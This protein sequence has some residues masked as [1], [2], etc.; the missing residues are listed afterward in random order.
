MLSISNI[1]SPQ[2]RAILCIAIMLIA[3]FLVTRLTK[4][5]RLPNVTGYLLAGMILGP[6][7]LGVLSQSAI[8]A[9]SFLTDIAPALIA[10]GVGK[11]LK[12]SKLR[13]N[14]RRGARAGGIRRLRHENA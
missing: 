4:K 3:G 7:C 11:Y 14:F 1:T 10:F 5:L 13:D 12:V 6:Y 8:D 9:M 2:A